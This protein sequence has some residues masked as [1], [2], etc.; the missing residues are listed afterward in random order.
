MDKKRVFMAL[1]GVALCGICVGIFN[2][3][4]LGADPFTV[5]VTGIGNL[6]GTGYGDAYTVVTGVFFIDSFLN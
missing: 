6:F 1:I 3:V 5:F 2:T 4:L